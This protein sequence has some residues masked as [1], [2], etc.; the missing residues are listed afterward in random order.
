M[1]RCFRGFYSF[2]ERSSFFVIFSDRWETIETN[3]N[4]W[5]RAGPSLKRPLNW[6]HDGGRCDPSGLRRK[7]KKMMWLP[8]RYSFDL[9]ARVTVT[10]DQVNQF[11]GREFHR[12]RRIASDSSGVG[13]ADRRAGVPCLL[14]M[15]RAAVSNARCHLLTQKGELH[16]HHSDLSFARPLLPIVSQHHVLKKCP[17]CQLFWQK[18]GSHLSSSFSKIWFTRDRHQ[19]PPMCRMP[20]H[21]YHQWTKCLKPFSV[22][23]KVPPRVHKS[24][25]KSGWV[26]GFLFTAL[27]FHFTRDL[28]IAKLESC[29]VPLRW[30][31]C[32]FMMSSLSLVEVLFYV[33]S[34]SMIREP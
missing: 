13:N 9:R 8:R 27:P 11:G 25:R 19:S 10:S 28:T 29:I 2:F 26:A 16:R 18:R 34:M 31:S 17:P 22:N 24:P 20:S 14:P 7:R 30:C 21:S 3:W 12:R 6:A 23:L 5:R 15:E 33:L 1:V 4:R 32:W